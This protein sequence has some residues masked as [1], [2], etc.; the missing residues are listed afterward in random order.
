[1]NKEIINKIREERIYKKYKVTNFALFAFL[2]TLLI[3]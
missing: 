1:M 3:V 2:I